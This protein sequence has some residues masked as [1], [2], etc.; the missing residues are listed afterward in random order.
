MTSDGDAHDVFL[1]WNRGA[2]P[3]LQSYTLYDESGTVLDGRDVGPSY[4]VVP[5][6]TR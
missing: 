1:T 4:R 3:D 2:E 5:L 6:G